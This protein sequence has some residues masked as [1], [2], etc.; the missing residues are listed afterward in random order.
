MDFVL[1]PLG[2][3]M[4]AAWLRSMLP[5]PQSLASTS[6]PSRF[7]LV[8]SSLALRVRPASS[9]FALS[10]KAC[11]GQA[12]VH[13]QKMYMKIQQSS[14]E[15]D[16]REGFPH[17]ISRHAVKVIFISFG[18]RL[19]YCVTQTD[20][21]GSALQNS[22]A[23]DWKLKIDFKKL[24]L[25]ETHVIIYYLLLCMGDC[26]SSSLAK[27]CW[28]VLKSVKVILLVFSWWL[29]EDCIKR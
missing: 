1:N 8:P 5:R 24:S 7:A 10:R 26:L 14:R 20:Q 19:R 23:M 25:E 3:T 21:S 17:E 27:S 15:D 29:F 4:A 13:V 11:G 12:E 16:L 6:P 2:F 9:R 18:S 22:A 28:V